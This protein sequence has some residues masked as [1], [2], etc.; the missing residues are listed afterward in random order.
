[1]ETYCLP[2]SPKQGFTAW[3]TNLSAGETDDA[4]QPPADK[5]H[6]TRLFVYIN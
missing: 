2:I 4:N 5:K 6:L 1:M 3:Q